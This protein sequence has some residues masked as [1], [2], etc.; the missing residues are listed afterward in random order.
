M[1]DQIIKR[2]WLKHLT[3][4]LTT[5]DSQLQLAALLA[6]GNLAAACIPPS[7]TY[8]HSSGRLT[9]SSRSPSVPLSKVG[10][11]EP[12][13]SI[14]LAASLFEIWR[15][16]LQK[17]HQV[18]DAQNATEELNQTIIL[19]QLIRTLLHLSLDSTVAFFIL[20]LILIFK[21]DGLVVTLFTYFPPSILA[22]ILSAV[23]ESSKND[24]DVDMKVPN[25][26]S[27]HHCRYLY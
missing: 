14:T 4:F 24:R 27:L 21:S 12:D 7:S 13:E 9:F 6:L 23:Q 22:D 16:R 5:S 25:Y 10:N 2:G 18:E 26:I 8:Y 19:Q 15:Q 1:R 3:G 17:E 11:I 20:S